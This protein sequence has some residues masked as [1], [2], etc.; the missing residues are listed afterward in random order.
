MRGDAQKPI[1]NMKSNGTIRKNIPVFKDVNSP[2]HPTIK[3]TIAPPAIPVHKIPDK[4]PWCFFT[5]FSAKEKIIDHITDIKKP[6]RGNETSATFGFPVNA[7]SKEVMVATLAK[8]NSFR[9][10]I[11]FKSNK[12]SRQP[13]VSI[14]QK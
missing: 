7:N 2:S 6:T 3:G 12:P 13:T 4:E 5:E 14:A 11:I 9:L 1:L 8:I 10:S